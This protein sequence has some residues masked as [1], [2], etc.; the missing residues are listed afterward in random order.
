MNPMGRKAKR[1]LS[2]YSS[3][4]H[5]VKRTGF[6]GNE[7]DLIVSFDPTKQRGNSMKSKLF[8]LI[9]VTALLAIAGVFTAF[10]VGGGEL[11]PVTVLTL[12]IVSMA[13]VAF[14][15]AAL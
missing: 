13:I 14:A 12:T 9:W 2:I 15:V 4:F 3:Q 7:I 10:A 6:E 8:I 11:V 1:G 5:F